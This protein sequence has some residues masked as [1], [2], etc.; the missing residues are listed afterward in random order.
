MKFFENN[1]NAFRW[2]CIFISGGLFLFLTIV[3]IN[4]TN[5]NDPGPV[6]AAFGGAALCMINMITLYIGKLDTE[7]D[8]LERKLR[9]KKL[10]IKIRQA[11]YF[12]DERNSITPTKDEERLSKFLNN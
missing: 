11:D 3:G 7:E 2:L 10:Q 6:F 12:L 5:R 9:E 1:H 8:K 4:E